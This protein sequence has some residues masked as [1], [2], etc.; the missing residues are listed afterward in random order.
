MVHGHKPDS[1]FLVV[2][3][4]LLSVSYLHL[5]LVLPTILWFR[6]LVARLQKAEDINSINSNGTIT[7]E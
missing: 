3:F 2:S 6:L 7:D 4:G 5:L 1:S